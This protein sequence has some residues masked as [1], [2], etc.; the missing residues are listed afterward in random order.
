MKTLRKSDK[1]WGIPTLA[2]LILSG[3]LLIYSNSV[4]ND[5][6]RFVGQVRKDFPVVTQVANLEEGISALRNAKYA[7]TTRGVILKNIPIVATPNPNESK[8][9][10]ERARLEISRANPQQ[11]LALNSIEERLYK[12]ESELSKMAKNGLGSYFENQRKGIEQIAQLTKEELSSLINKVPSY[13]MLQR[14]KLKRRHEQASNVGLIFGVLS[15]VNLITYG[16]YKFISK[17]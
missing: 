11:N 15:G 13:I 8:D 16:T 4:H 17:N 9:Y 12:L 14:D 1:F 7:L 5:F 10:L 2:S 6:N 3:G